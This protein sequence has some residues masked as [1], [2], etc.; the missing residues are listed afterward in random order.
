VAKSKTSRP[1]K[2]QGAS[3]TVAD[4]VEDAVDATSVDAVS[5]DGDDTSSPVEEVAAEVASVEDAVIVEAPL[6]QEASADDVSDAPSDESVVVET[7][8]VEAVA[9]V[10]S[11]ETDEAEDAAPESDTDA[12]EPVAAEVVREV[13]PEKRGGFMPMV[14]GGVVAAGLGF[15]AS[16]YSA[17]QSAANAPVVPDLTEP[18]DAQVARIDDLAA[19]FDALPASEPFDPAELSQEIAG[20]QGEIAAVSAQL[21][22]IDARIAALEAMPAEGSEAPQVV[23]VDLSPLEAE[24]AALKAA[25]D[26]QSGVVA[27]MIAT[28]EAAKAS[29]E[30]SAK[31]AVA[32]GAVTEILVALESGAGFA[33]AIE[34]LKQSGAVEVPAVLAEVA[35]TGLPTLS[36]LTSSF[37]DAA[38][39]ALAAARSSADPETESGGLGSLFARQLGVRSVVPREGNDPD[40]ILS[41]MEAAVK[42]GNISGALA[43]MEAL[44][45]AAKAPLADWAAQA[46]LRSSALQEAQALATSLNS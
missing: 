36:D 25:L 22:A 4:G 33:P 38:R 2:P 15:G 16:Q 14:I 43:E 44:P 19:R 31:R 32:S 21:D 10:E 46:N 13:V 12:V 3:K 27:G 24:I 39:S 26:D 29:A 8:E 18:L 20:V 42:D 1:K 5:E 37:P 23:P 11:S 17:S 34:T 30:E 7:S 45:D 6:D 41:R 9:P 28:A 35:E 40:A